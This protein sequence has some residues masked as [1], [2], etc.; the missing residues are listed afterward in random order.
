MTYRYHLSELPD[1]LHLLV[2]VHIEND[3]SYASASVDNMI[4]KPEETHV[5]FFKYFNY[6]S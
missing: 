2:S 3:L 1:G 6:S 4:N 5:L